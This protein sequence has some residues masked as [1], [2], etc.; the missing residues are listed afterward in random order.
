M[1]DDEAELAGATC[2]LL[3]SA[4]VRYISDGRGSVFIDKNGTIDHILSREHKHEALQNHEMLYLAVV[5]LLELVEHQLLTQ[6]NPTQDTDMG[7]HPTE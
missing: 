7:T 4:T 3:L 1:D 6:P 5:G 2:T